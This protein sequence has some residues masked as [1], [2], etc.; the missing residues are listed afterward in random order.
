METCFV[1]F[2]MNFTNLNI[3]FL[4]LILFVLCQKN[5]YKLFLLLFCMLLLCMLQL[6]YLLVSKLFSKLV[7]HSKIVVFRLFFY[8]L[9]WY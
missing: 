2:I 7:N 9:P 6:K 8:N 3:C 4:S 5:Q 1:S